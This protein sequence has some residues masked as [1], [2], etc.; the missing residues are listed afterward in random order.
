MK[1]HGSTHM[2]ESNSKLDLFLKLDTVLGD[3]TTPDSSGHGNNGA[4]RGALHLVE[5]PLLGRC[6]SF[7]G[8][9]EHISVRDPFHDDH[10]FTLSVWVRPAVINDGAYHG[11][12]GKQGD[13][14]RKPGLWLAPTHGGLHYDSYE[15]S[16]GQRYADILEG[17]FT[18]P[19]EWVHVAW[20]KDGRTYCIY[21]NGI[22]FATRGAPARVYSDARSDYWIGRVDN[23]WKGL[24]AKAR[25]YS[26]SLSAVELAQQASQ[27]L[28]ELKGLPGNVQLL[29]GMDGSVFK[30]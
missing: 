10:A 20:V 28:T 8:A 30:P 24:L 2:N 19:G 23:H 25:V 4:I 13:A 1:A 3:G 22:L 7:S 14:Y 27:D 17:F 15:S 12:M 11:F 6:S 29:P 16:S 5:D 26:R 18:Q 21:R 9:G